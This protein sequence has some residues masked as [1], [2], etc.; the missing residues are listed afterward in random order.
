LKEKAMTEPIHSLDRIKISKPCDADWDSMIGNDQ[1]RFCAHCNLHVTNLSKLTR[2]EA[3]LLVAR[4]KGRLCVRFVQGS[5]GAVLTKDVPERLHQIV[6]RVS[7]IAAGAFTAA[8]TLSNAAAQNGADRSAMIRPPSVAMDRTVSPG[9]GAR[10]SGAITDPNGAAVPGVAIT[11]TNRASHTAFEY[12]TKEDGRYEFVLP[13]AGLY[14]VDVE[15]AGFAKPK[16]MEFELEA[17]SNQNL[18]FNLELPEITAE[19]E[20][21]AEGKIQ[22]TVTMGV[23]AVSEPNEPLIRAAYKD[24]LNG[25]LE[26]IPTTA[27]I[28]THDPYTQTSAL[29]YAVE[30][31]N[32]EMVRALLSAGANINSANGS[33]QTPLMHLGREASVELV[34]DLIAAGADVKARNESGE[35]VLMNIARACTLDVFKELVAA[36]AR[37]DGTDNSRNTVLI[38]AAENDDARVIKFL[39]ESG[40][41]LDARNEDGEAALWIAAR[42]GRGE[43]LK[44]LI[45]AGAAINLTA[46]E[47]AEALMLAARNDD[48]TSVKLLLKAGA[49]PNATDSQKTTVL[50]SAAEHGTADSVKAL[51]DAGADLNAV[52]EKGW[53]AMMNANDVAN[54]RVLLDAGADATI[55]NN[56]GETA[57]KMAIRYQQ[58]EIVQLLKSRGVPE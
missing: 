42:Y 33:G 20:I 21:T 35:T 17:N 19:V 29:A 46:S 54:V 13:E 47:L 10:L 18:N 22:D 24:D 40:A 49:D 14:M 25:V 3:T 52:N 11:V 30:N 48:S 16:P 31:H 1:V 57:L 8:V 26:L 2:R 37:I 53:T 41:S 56:E 39:I 50:M 34:R 32:R 15:P 45:D 55:K 9:A 38:R 28:N 27:D 5:G 44:T 58:T 51:I 36:G 6:R 7:R 43:V 12:T 4:S 23:V